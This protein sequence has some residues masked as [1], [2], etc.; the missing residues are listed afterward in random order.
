VLAK[1]TGF[2]VLKTLGLGV[3]TTL[4]KEAFASESSYK[5]SI[6]GTFSILEFAG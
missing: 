5:E 4:A 6:D 2:S 1:H 3:L